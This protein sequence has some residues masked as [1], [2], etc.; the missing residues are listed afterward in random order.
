MRRRVVR[1]WWSVEVRLW[2]VNVPP[3]SWDDGRARTRC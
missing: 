2:K 3:R 1:A